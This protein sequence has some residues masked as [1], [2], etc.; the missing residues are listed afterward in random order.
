M[1]S[2]AARAVSLGGMLLLVGAGCA[3]ASA[4]TS[5]GTSSGISRSPPPDLPPVVVVAASPEGEM[6]SLPAVTTDN[7]SQLVVAAGP[8]VLVSAS[9]TYEGWP[10]SNATDGDIQT[11]WYSNTNDSAAKGATP[12]FQLEFPEPSTV[13]RVTVLGNRDPQFLHGYTIL[14]GRVDVIDA[15]GRVIASMKSAG[16]G[17]RR[18]FDFRFERPV[19]SVKI[20]RFT[21]LSDEGNKN[22]YGDVAIAELQVE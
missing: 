19:E 21:S 5:S 3:G 16:T 8:A 17:N 2:I 1:R 22:S 15:R 9:S 12:Y 14:S 10:P 18:D 13:R 20:V 6:Q 4:V 11:W 7:R